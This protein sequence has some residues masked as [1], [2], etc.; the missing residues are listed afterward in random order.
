MLINKCCVSAIPVFL[1]DAGE[2]AD[3]TMQQKW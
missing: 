3:K 1:V 2:E